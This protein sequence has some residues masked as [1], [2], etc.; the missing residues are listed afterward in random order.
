MKKR[1]ILFLNECRV[2][3]AKQIIAPQLMPAKTYGDKMKRLYLFTKN[4]ENTLFSYHTLLF[5]VRA[6]NLIFGL[7][8]YLACNVFIL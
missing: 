1:K 5:Y 4:E 3:S 2:G 7:E 6:A 8:L